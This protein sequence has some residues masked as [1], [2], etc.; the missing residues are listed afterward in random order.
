MYYYYPIFFKTLGVFVWIINGLDPAWYFS[1][2]GLAWDATFKITKVRLEL[3]SDPD[4]LLMIEGGIRGGIATIPHPHAKTNDEY[5][6]TEFN[7]AE[8]CKFI[9]Y[10]DAN[11]LYG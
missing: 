10:L 6:G 7:P 5:T 1:A 9:S 8:E 2:P 4:M 11:N 3:L